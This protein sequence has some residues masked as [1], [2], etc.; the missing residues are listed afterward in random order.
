MMPSMIAE[1]AP[2]VVGLTVGFLDGFFDGFLDDLDDF[3][4][5]LLGDFLD[6]VSLSDLDSV[7]DSVKIFVDFPCKWLFWLF[8]GRSAWF[9]SS[10]SSLSGLAPFDTGGVATVLVSFCNLM[11]LTLF[12]LFA[13]AWGGNAAKHDS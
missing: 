9:C 11:V 13:K 7:R 5:C 10:M 12:L 8:V 4:G 3:L 1:M 6:L 2:L